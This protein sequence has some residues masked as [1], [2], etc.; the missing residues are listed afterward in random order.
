VDHDGWPDL[1]VNGTVTGGTSHPDLLFRRV[2]GAF[3]DATPPSLRVE[4]D[5]GATFVDH[6]RDGDLDLAVTGAQE[7]GMHL[8]FQNLL[9]PEYARHALAVRVLDGE[10]RATRAGAMVRILAASTDEVLGAAVVDSGSGY[11][12]QNDLPV[13]FGLASSQPV[14]VEVWWPANGRTVT[15]RRSGVD[16]EEHR[17]GSM[18]VR[19]GG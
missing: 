15:V 10:G 16:P 14:D 11:D 17:G 6:D 2:D 5:H 12:S 9:R 4:A 1:Y 19:V 18:E 3:E 8:L 7:G 13:V